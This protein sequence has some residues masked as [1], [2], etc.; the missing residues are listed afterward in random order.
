MVVS[1]KEG[2]RKCLVILEGWK[3]FLL[4]WPLLNWSLMWSKITSTYNIKYWLFHLDA[5]RLSWFM[6]FVIGIPHHTC[7]ALGVKELMF[8]FC[9]S[10]IVLGTWFSEEKKNYILHTPEDFVLFCFCFPFRGIDKTVHRSQ[11]M[12]S[13]P[14]CLAQIDISPQR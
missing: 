3:T 14:F 5:L 8:Q 10:W 4:C 12:L 7:S 11:D 6:V 2:R 1:E 9:G 13:F